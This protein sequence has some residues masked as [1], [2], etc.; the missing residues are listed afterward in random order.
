MSE[1]ILGSSALNDTADVILAITT[2]PLLEKS[3]ECLYTIIKNRFGPKNSIV[4]KISKNMIDD[5][6]ELYNKANVIV[7]ITTNPYLEKRGECLH[8]IIK[9]RFGSKK[10][11]VN[12]MKKKSKFSR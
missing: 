1:K 4:R 6:T 10:T 9:N 11:I 8:T 3:G 5:I 2:N 12:K 7:V